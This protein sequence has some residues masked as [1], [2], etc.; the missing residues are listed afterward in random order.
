[1][2][3]PQLLG[4]SHLGL[5]VRDVPAAMRFWTGVFGFR[6]VIDEP[7]FCF[8]VRADIG[9][10]LGLSDHAGAVGGEFDELRVGLDHL[11]LAVADVRTLHAWSGRL[12]EYGVPH[13][14]VEASDAGMHLNL[15]APDAFPVELFVLDPAVAPSFGIG[16]PADA[17]A[18]THR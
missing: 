15:R 5:S 12:D 3:P 13:S 17:V 14:P 1:V 16:D 7:G 11:A 2:T 8:L 6:A 18:R 9:V 10:A 4:L